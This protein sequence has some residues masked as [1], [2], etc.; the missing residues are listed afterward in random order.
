MRYDLVVF[1]F[2][3]TLA[4]STEWM[5]G[6]LNDLA[7]RHRFRQVDRA[8]IEALRGRPTREVMR[9]LGVS[10][11]R[12]PF[13]AADMRRRSAAD[14]GSI[15][16]FPG[17]P[18]CLRDLTDAGVTVGIVSSNGEATVREVLGECEHLIDAYAC[19]ASLFGKQRKLGGVSRKLAVPP[20]RAL[21]VG[22]ET[23]DV[24]AAKAA[25]FDSAAVSW[26]YNTRSALAWARPTYLLDSFQ[27]LAVAIADQPILRLLQ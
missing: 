27:E 22:D 25:G 7:V 19:D 10:P 6:V 15:P 20:E 23:R 2:D 12:L 8:Q 24:H 16:M 26:G 21:Y 3:G 5:I 18:E 17:V 14:A 11:W 1:D 4:D 13:I 9:D